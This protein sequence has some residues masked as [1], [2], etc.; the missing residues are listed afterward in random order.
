MF[1][2]SI[3]SKEQMGRV[4]DFLLEPLF[5]RSAH[6]LVR[7]LLNLIQQQIQSPW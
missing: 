4:G 3:F 6:F 5:M 1:E 7:N 2:E